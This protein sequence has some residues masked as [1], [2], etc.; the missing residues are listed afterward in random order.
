MTEEPDMECGT[1]GKNGFAGEICSVC[2]RPI[3]QERQYTLSEERSGRAPDNGERYTR[4]GYVPPKIITNLP[5]SGG[6]GGQ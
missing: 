5:G 3:D 2:H 4:T 1:C 6:P